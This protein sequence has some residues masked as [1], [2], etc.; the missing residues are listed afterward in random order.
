MTDR[1]MGTIDTINDT[2]IA[3]VKSVI[4]KEEMKGKKLHKNG[5]V[6]GGK[7]DG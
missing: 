6:V 4:V 3:T 1:M 7:S 2:N 5:G